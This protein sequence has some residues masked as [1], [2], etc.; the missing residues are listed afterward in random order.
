MYYELLGLLYYANDL[1]ETARLR[2]P[3]G[4]IRDVAEQMKELVR[5]FVT[6]VTTHRQ[7]WRVN[8]ADTTSV[9]STYGI[10]YIGL[11]TILP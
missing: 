2:Y 6:A 11:L 7:L 10:L 1:W 4:L 8:A 5:E 3:P 9:S